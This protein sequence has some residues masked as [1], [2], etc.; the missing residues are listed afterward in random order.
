MAVWG[1]SCHLDDFE[2]VVVA[3]EADGT[4][5]A[6]ATGAE[7]FRHRTT[8][9]EDVPTKLW[10]LRAAVGT[11][12]GH[13]RPAVVVIR[14]TDFPPPPT[15][16]RDTVIRPRLQVEGMLAEVSRWH[17]TNVAVLSARAIADLCGVSREVLEARS[18]ELFGKEALEA[19]TAAL[20]ALVRSG[21]EPWPTA[22]ARAP[23]RRSRRRRT[24]RQPG[25]R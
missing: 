25:S 19:G 3:V 4:T 6:D 18:I 12:L 20:A 23:A 1:I 2:P 11:K 16:P 14:Q 17:G 13:S 8:E 10:S 7:V 5:L 22:P 21:G 24:P 9:A 15:R